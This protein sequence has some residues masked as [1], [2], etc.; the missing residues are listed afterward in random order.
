MSRDKTKQSLRDFIVVIYVIMNFMKYILSI[1]LLILGCSYIQATAPEK[2]AS[3]GRLDHYNNVLLK[4]I[5]KDEVDQAK[6]MSIKKQVKS[7]RR[8]LYKNKKS[9]VRKSKKVKK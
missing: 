7:M 6:I 9:S 1:C 5:S 8:E 3:K 4:E 2:G